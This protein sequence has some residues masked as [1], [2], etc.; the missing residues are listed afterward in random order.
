MSAPELL[1][2]EMASGLLPWLLNDS[3]DEDEKLAVLEHARACVICR[4][5]LSDLE[6]LRDSI[7]QTSAALPIP[8]PDMRNINTRIDGLIARR[9][10]GRNCLSQIRDL[11][12]NYWRIAFIAQSILLLAAVAL[13]LWPE[14]K[15][16]EFSTL[17]QSS[18]LRDGLYVRVVFSPELASPELSSLLDRF[19]L[20]L[21]TGPSARGVFTL[22]LPESSSIEDRDKLV[23]RLQE[24]PRVL[25]AQP[26][27]G[28]QVR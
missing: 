11:L 12:E 22:A 17:T 13:L 21:V 15:N 24:D 1:P 25:F 28:E 9:R 8:A 6:R 20:T 14:P 3:L 18:D 16:N 5:E 4:R 10:W 27:T 7:T 26:I 2:H 19:E 23:T